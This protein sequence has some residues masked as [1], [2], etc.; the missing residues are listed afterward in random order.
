MSGTNYDTDYFSWLY[1]LKITNLHN[2]KFI[3]KWINTS[4][5]HIAQLCPTRG[6]V[7][8]FARP[9]VEVFAVV[10]VSYIAYWKPVLILIMLNLLYFMQVFFRAT[11]LPLQLGFEH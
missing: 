7:E 5:K 2:T 9:A 1:Q 11:L 10:K 3:N 4:D 6:P 8:G